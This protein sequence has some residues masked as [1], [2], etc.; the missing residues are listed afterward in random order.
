M[1]VDRSLL[2]I[3]Y[4]LR[5]VLRKQK[6]FGIEEITVFLSVELRIGEDL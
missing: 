3:I 4:L 5:V 1:G 6:I 2:K